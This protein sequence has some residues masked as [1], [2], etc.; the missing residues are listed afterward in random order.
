MHISSK[1]PAQTLSTTILLTILLATTSTDFVKAADT[2][3]KAEE[4]QTAPKTEDKQTVKTEEKAQSAPANQPPA[5]VESDLEDLVNKPF[6]AVWPEGWKTKVLPGPLTNSGKDLGGKRVRSTRV[7]NGV[8]TV[9]ELTFFPRTDKGQSNVAEEIKTVLSNVKSGYETNGFS[10]ELGPVQNT[11]LSKLDANEALVTV[12]TPG[13]KMLQN[14]LLAQ[15]EDYLYSL[16]FT[17]RQTQYDLY[18]PVYERLRS[19]LVLK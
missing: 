3:N 15:S 18:K 12:T 10:A 1:L 11:K 7:D 16:T 19:S 13:F 5:P 2:Q 6:E 9:I 8:L 14:I 17:G 4:Q